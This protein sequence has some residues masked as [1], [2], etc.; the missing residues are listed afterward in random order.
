M[1]RS[2]PF[3]HAF[4]LPALLNGREVMYIRQID[5]VNG[6]DVVEVV[7]QLIIDDEPS[8]ERLFLRCKADG[9]VRVQDLRLTFSGPKDAKPFDKLG[10]D[11]FEKSQALRNMLIEGEVEVLTETQAKALKKFNYTTNTKDAALDKILC[12][13]PAHE[14][15]S[16]AGTINE[17]DPDIDEITSKTEI[18]TDAD[19]IISRGWSKNDE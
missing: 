11:V 13:K 15:A 19:D 1:T 2:I 7:N 17:D 3:S 10:F 18:T 4:I 6:E 5:E 14:V 9:Y 12:N 8:T 16:S